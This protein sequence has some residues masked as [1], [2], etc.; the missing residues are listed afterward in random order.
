VVRQFGE[1]SVDLELRV[2]IKEARR[3]MDTISFMTDHIKEAFDR[4]GIEIPY[5]KRDISIV[6]SGSVG[7]HQ[8]ITET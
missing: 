5:P 6:S 7:D 4:E 3:R 2:W 8:Q 1:S